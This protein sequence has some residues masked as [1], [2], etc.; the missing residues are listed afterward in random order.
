[1]NEI[2]YPTSRI[3]N[4][5]ISSKISKEFD[6][7]K[8]VLEH[9]QSFCRID[10]DPHSFP[11]AI[12]KLNT[13]PKG[14]ALLFNSGKLVI[15]GAK[16]DDE[17]NNGI[18]EIK[19]L[20]LS[21]NIQ[22]IENIKIQI[23]NIVG[24]GDL[25]YNLSLNKIANKLDIV[26]YDP[27]V[28]PGL[29]TRL[30]YPKVAILLFGTG[31]LVVAGAKTKKDIHVSVEKIDLRIKEIMKERRNRIY[32]KVIFMIWQIIIISYICLLLLINM[33]LNG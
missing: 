16:N 20:Y 22:I 25:G 17:I 10:Y 2:I 1:M 27:E 19:E 29:V 3:T 15:A 7:N 6:L 23:N 26:E 28:F 13:T 21:K 30:N 8:M 4:I 32:K 31:K 12:M 33:W 11:G 5:V 14:T 18:Q 24:A 9:D